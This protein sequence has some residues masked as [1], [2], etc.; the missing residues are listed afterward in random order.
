MKKIVALAVLSLLFTFFGSSDS[1]ADSEKAPSLENWC[2]DRMVI[3]SPPGKSQFENAKETEEEG[4]DRYME[5]ARDAISVAY[6]PSEAPLFPGPYGRAKTLAAMLGVV[7]SESGFRRDVDLGKGAASK[8]DGGRSWCL[9][10][11]QLGK[12]VDGKTPLRV[13]LKG[14]GVEYVWNGKGGFGGEDLIADRKTC[15]RVGLHIMRVSFNS[16]GSLP[17]PER[18]SVY[19]SGNCTD[20][21]AASK[22]RMDKAIR[23][24]A[25]VAPPLDDTS[26]L[27]ALGLL[28][29]GSVATNP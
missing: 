16:C 15:L 27:S 5:I 7:H 11:V 3:W 10:Q 1:F 18:L 9:M 20:G 4:K 13:A 28:D 25:A 26:E 19:T 23:W 8:G 6:D 24:L 14:D 2:V 21:R 17:V 12:A 22:V 29:P